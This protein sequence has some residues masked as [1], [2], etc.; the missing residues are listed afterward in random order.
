MT[1]AQVGAIAA[2]LVTGGVSLWLVTRPDAPQ[3][4]TLNTQQKIAYVAAATG[5]WPELGYCVDVE[6]VVYADDEMDAS[7]AP[8]QGPWR[9]CHQADSDDDGG[10][11]DP[12][13]RVDKRCRQ[14]ARLLCPG[15]QTCED[16][17]VAACE[18][19][20]LQGARIVSVTAPFAKGGETKVARKIGRQ[21][22]T[23]GSCACAMAEDAGNCKCWDGAPP[24]SDAGLKIRI[25]AP[26]CSA[27]AW[28]GNAC[29]RTICVETEIR[30]MVPNPGPGALVPSACKP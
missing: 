13:D 15:D 9:L 18:Q 6:G 17:G 26:I 1:R 3:T 4:A 11:W 14:A 23:G 29:L 5:L 27:G 21:S 22:I 16:N 10:L 7:P 20:I 28:T 24:G 19:A 25:G 12:L 8:T 30:E 2:I